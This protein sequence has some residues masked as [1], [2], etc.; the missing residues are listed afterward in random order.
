MVTTR[1][2]QTEIKAK[3]NILLDVVEEKHNAEAPNLYDEQFL[4]SSDIITDLKI[5]E[6]APEPLVFNVNPDQTR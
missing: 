2:L 6:G 4:L 3:R 5:G 1:A